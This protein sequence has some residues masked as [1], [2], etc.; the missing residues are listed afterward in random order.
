MQS[1]EELLQLAKD[2]LKTEAGKKL[3]G[4]DTDVENLLSGKWKS[5]W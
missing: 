3:A 1:K 2:F 5:I 4:L